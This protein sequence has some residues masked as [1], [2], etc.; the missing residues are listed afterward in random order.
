MVDKSPECH[1]HESE[2]SSSSSINVFKPRKFTLGGTKVE[3]PYALKPYPSQLTCMAKAVTGARLGQN[4]LLE[5]PTGSGKTMAMLCSLLAWQKQFREEAELA[6]RQEMAQKLQEFSES[7]AAQLV[8]QGGPD[9]E[10]SKEKEAGFLRKQTFELS[11]K[12]DSHEAQIPEN[13]TRNRMSMLDSWSDDEDVKVATPVTILDSDDS[14]EYFKSPKKKHLKSSAPVKTPHKSE[15]REKTSP[16]KQPQPEKKVG[17]EPAYKPVKVKVPKIFF[18]TRTHKQIT[19]VVEEL[20]RTPYSNT[21]MTILNSRE[22]SCLRRLEDPFKSKT[23]MCKSLL[24]KNGMEVEENYG[25]KKGCHLKNN[26]VRQ[27]I[28]HLMDA[29][30]LTEAPWDI[31]D[32]VAGCK[33]FSICPYFA[34]RDLMATADI[35]FCPYNYIVDPLIRQSMNINLSGNILLFDEAH[36]IEDAFRESNS[37]KFT[38]GILNEA[39]K[40]CDL[41]SMISSKKAECAQLKEAFLTFDKWM[42]EASS[43]LRLEDSFSRERTCTFSGSRFANEMEVAGFDKKAFDLFVRAAEALFSEEGAGQMSPTKNAEVVKDEEG[44]GTANMRITDMFKA[45]PQLRTMVDGLKLVMSRI[46]SENL[47]NRDDYN[48]V[49]FETAFKVYREGPSEGGW[50]KKGSVDASVELGLNLWCM[51]PAIGFADLQDA[52]SVIVTSGTLSPMTSFQSELGAKFPHSLSTDHVISPSQVWVG[53]VSTG[54]RGKSVNGVYRNAVTIDYQ[55]EIGL[56]I[57]GICSIVPFGV[58]CFFPSYAALENVM[59][60][61]QMSGAWHKLT[62][63]K[64]VIVE[65]RQAKDFSDAMTRFDSSI[66]RAEE[67]VGQTQTGALLLAVCRGKVSEGIDFKDNHARAVITVSIPYPNI[68]DL[69]IKLKKEYNDKN[70]HRQLLPGNQWYEIQAFRAINQ[71]LGRCIRHKNDWGAII[72]LDDRFS[73]QSKATKSISKWAAKNLTCYSYWIDVEEGLTNFVKRMTSN[74]SAE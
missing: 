1:K 18:A 41:G 29:M 72:L 28:E 9:I 53:S 21:K 62:A 45:S 58:L 30:D 64:D 56:S 42:T 13:P 19:Q 57:L 14:D 35:I 25:R 32:F 11:P 49:L 61:W 44:L 27:P 52:R 31:E 38:A 10:I 59:K 71:A 26:L 43:K 16:K 3:F 17:E 70:Q 39:V 68:K 37:F 65:P 50:Q 5:S 6:A 20:S 74:S 67:G 22:H 8:N 34:T 55:D 4:C 15:K 33:K 69:N 51:N 47:G 48:V 2:C 63:I 36:N 66:R 23:E 46:F 40:N 60:R 73:E 7:N 54:P 12:G 24:E